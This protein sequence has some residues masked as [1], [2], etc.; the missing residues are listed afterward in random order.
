MHHTYDFNAPAFAMLDGAA[1]AIDQVDH[2]TKMPIDDQGRRLCDQPGW[3]PELGIALFEHDGRRFLAVQ[4]EAL[5]AHLRADAA[6]KGYPGAELM[7]A[8]HLIAI[9]RLNPH[10]QGPLV[11]P[12]CPGVWLA[13][14]APLGAVRG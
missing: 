6:G 4:P 12:P 3:Y 13:V 7:R 10:F 1:Q 11:C 14:E 2:L 9:L 8:E 5:A